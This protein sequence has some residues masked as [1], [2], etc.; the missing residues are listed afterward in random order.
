MLQCNY[1]L[2]FRSLSYSR[3]RG[4]IDTFSVLFVCSFVVLL[5]FRQWVCVPR[6]QL[7]VHSAFL[8]VLGN[9]F[10]LFGGIS[11][12]LAQHGRRNRGE[13]SGSPKER[14]VGN[15]VP[16]VSVGVDGNPNFVAFLRHVPKQFL[17]RLGASESKV[18]STG[19]CGM[20]P[21]MIY[22]NQVLSTDPSHR[23]QQGQRWLCQ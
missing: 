9:Q 23:R 22:P 20:E 12:S 7:I 21:I 11:L 14:R 16:A 10:G 15:H 2:R 3:F 8:G 6:H 19:D 5:A 13:S 18:L 4:C 17:I 1:C